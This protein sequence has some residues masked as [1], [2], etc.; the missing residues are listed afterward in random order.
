MSDQLHLRI[1]FLCDIACLQLFY[2]NSNNNEDAK[3]EF[4]IKQHSPPLLDVPKDL[5]W[6]IRG[7]I[8]EGWTVDPL[9]RPSASELLRNDAFKL[10]GMDLFILILKLNLQLLQRHKV[11]SL[12]FIL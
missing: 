5:P 12:L 11:T 6:L 1:T 2:H 10:L 3:M 4:Q 8:L 7:L 9:A